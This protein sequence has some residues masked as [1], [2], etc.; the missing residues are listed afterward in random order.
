MVIIVTDLNVCGFYY[1]H[2]IYS[3]NITYMSD[4]E[5]VSRPPR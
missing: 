2:I 3:R 5:P 4:A 1:E